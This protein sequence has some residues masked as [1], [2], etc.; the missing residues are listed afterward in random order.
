MLVKQTPA[1]R[2]EAKQKLVVQASA[3]S[4]HAVLNSISK[5]SSGVVEVVE[6]LFIGSGRDGRDVEQ[7]NKLK[8]DTG[9]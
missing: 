1:Q 5:L 4:Q 8:I 7:L 2:R 6:G 9:E 3:Q